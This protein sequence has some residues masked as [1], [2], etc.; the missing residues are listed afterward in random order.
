MRRYNNTYVFP[1]THKQL[2][3]EK[4]VSLS[5]THKGVRSIGAF[6]DGGPVTVTFLHYWSGFAMFDPGKNYAN[7][8]LLVNEMKVNGT[9]LWVLLQHPDYFC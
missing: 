8:T 7:P 6:I 4:E 3:N 5:F 1:R 2:P 9:S